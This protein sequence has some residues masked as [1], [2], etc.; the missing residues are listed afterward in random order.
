VKAS[1]ELA[2]QDVHGQ[3]LAPTWNVLQNRVAEPDIEL[4]PPSPAVSLDEFEQRAKPGQI[5]LGQ[6]ARGDVSVTDAYGEELCAHSVPIAERVR[7]SVVR[8]GLVDADVT[9]LSPRYPR[10]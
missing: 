2:A 1:A 10:R 5:T 6:K 7:G 9:W 4:A 8:R 3:V